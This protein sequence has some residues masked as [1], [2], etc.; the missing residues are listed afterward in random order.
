[1][2]E[3][4]DAHCHPD[5]EKFNEDRDTVLARMAENGVTRCAAAGSDMD[6]SRRVIALSEKYKWITAVAGVHPHEAKSFRET[7]ADIL[8]GWY[9]MGKIRA[10]GEIGLDYFYDLSPRETQQE[11][12]RRQ[13]A[14]AWE[15]GAPV[16]FH[17]R[18]AHTDMLEIMKK[19]R[20]HLT[21]G[22]IHCFSGSR[23]IADEYL[24]LGYMISFAGPV[25]FKK[26]PK[27]CEAA[28][29]VP[30]GRLLAETDSPYLTPEPV[31]GRRNEPANVRYVVQKL[32]DLRGTDYETMAA[33]TFRNAEE[34]YGPAV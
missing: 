9:C 15:I 10:I 4:F 1:M 6:S 14:L 20:P 7:D 8:S 21:P 25:T 19:M 31:R 3:L 5:D 23:E 33:M 24:K 34:F 18:D 28:L 30:D 11:V 29:F 13:M 22:V 27:L 2:T 17:I 32:A 26:A 16:V 12:C